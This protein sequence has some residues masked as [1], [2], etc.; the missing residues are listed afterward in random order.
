MRIDERIA[1]GAEPAFSFEFFPPKTDDGVV[2]L[3]VALG[4]AAGADWS[5]RSCRSPTAPAAP[6]ADRQPSTRVA[7]QGRPRHRGDG[8]PHLRRRDR[9][10]AARATL[11]TMREAGI[12]NVLALRGD[13]P[14][15]VDATFVDRAEAACARH[16]L[17][18][19]IRARLR[20]LPRRR[21]LSR[22]CTS[23]SES[24]RDRPQAHP[25]KVDAGASS[26]SRSCSSTTPFYFALRA[27]ARA[28]PGITCPIVPGIMPITNVDQ[29][30][31]F[32]EHVRRDDPA[33]LSRELELRSDDPEAVL[34]LGVATRRCSAPSCCQR[35]RPASTSTR[36]TA[37]LRRG[38]S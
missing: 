4:R 28:T 25:R 21:V 7:H 26:S 17:I 29:I 27:T 8:A 34:Q 35:R 5:P 22:R 6:P 2:Y 11:D 12:E 23:Q 9:G 31:R 30:K 32:T 33:G 18:E 10:R 38:P 14:A 19:L 37:R 20:L 24:T 16:E 36:S 13:P 15:G 3:I 1:S